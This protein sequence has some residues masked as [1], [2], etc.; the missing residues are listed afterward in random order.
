MLLLAVAGCSGDARPS[1]D[2]REGFAERGLASWYGDELA[3]APTASGER[4]D[5]AGFTAAHRSLP[6]G[7]LAEVTDLATGRSIV[8][9][10]NDRG[11]HRGDRIIDL[12]SGAAHRLGTDRRPVSDVRIRSIAEG[13]AGEIRA[14]GRAIADPVLP[15]PA[16]ASGRYIVQ[17][18][19]FADE[20][21]ARLL[22][23]RIGAQ[24]APSGS[25]WRVR[26][27]PYDAETA[28]RARDA[29]A[30]RGYADAHLLATD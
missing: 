11:P 21:R 19:S 2:H 7:S 25:L 16:S 26:Q 6:L 5:P 22:A 18:A 30:A 20:S 23:A 24:V 13:R 17:I 14:A 28:Q 4:F 10:I 27:G 8:V 12:S 15:L 3:G 9:R 1:I 29:I